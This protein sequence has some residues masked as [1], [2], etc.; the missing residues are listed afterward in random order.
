LTIEQAGKMLRDKKLSPVEL[1]EACLRRIEKLNP[2]LNA[3][4]TVT[5]ETALTQ[6]KA[7]EAELRAGRDRGPLQGIPIALKDLIDT[8]GIR[9]T[10]ASKHYQDRV[11][12]DDAEV[13]RRLKMAG[14]IL[15]GKA[16]M[17]EFAYN[18]TSETS[19]FGRVPNPWN[20]ERSP[21]GSSGGSAV[22]VA[23]GMCLGALGSD[24]GGSIR[25][26]AALCGITGF[27][28][29]Y[30][31]VSTEG[32]APLA[33]SLDHVGPM[34]RT[35]ADAALLLGGMSGVTPQYN[36]NV[37]ALQ[38]GIPRAL[39]FDKIDPQLEKAV[40]EA[41]K[42]LASLTANTKEV[43]LPEIPMSSQLTFFP[44][45]YARIITAE[46]Y[47]FHEDM[48]NQ[49]PERYHPGTRKSIEGGATVTTPQYIRAHR[50]MQQLRANSTRLFENVELLIT[51]SAPGPA[52]KFGSGDLVFLRNAAYWNL[53]GL[54][55]ISIPCGF[56][57]DGL[58][59]GL[60]I[61]GPAGRDDTV[62]SLASAYQQVTDWHTRRPPMA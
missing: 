6:A 58:P 2:S 47:A 59:L 40:A 7:L 44:E 23:A 17:D 55:S 31:R 61:T 24:T 38:L 1:T 50:Q 29:S 5:G 14:A 41:A 22:A 10:A 57:T 3:F 25:L 15:I 19:S 26:P 34:C 48:L 20:Q 28:Q 56:T 39:F 11:P 54:P 33:W 32:V 42:V 35:A 9:T 53:Y 46:A 49:H 62:L 43:V 51:P 52:F 60:Q 36:R 45:A 18:F 16:N 12:K 8:A 4:I 13:V 27:K 37:K 21:G 30:G